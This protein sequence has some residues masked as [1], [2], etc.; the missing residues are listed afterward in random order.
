M[1]V[2]EQI[3]AR[4]QRPRSAIRSFLTKPAGHGYGDYAVRSASGRRYRVAMRSPSLFENYCSCADFAVNPLGTSMHVE[5]L[6]IRLRRRFGRSFDRQ[7][8]ER[9]RASLSLHYGGTLNV[10]IRLP[11]DASPA[12]QKIAGEHFDSKGFPGKKHLRIF[13]ALLEKLRAADE[14]V[15]VY[16]DALDSDVFSNQPG[17]PKP[18]ISPE[19]AVPV[20]LAEAEK[21]RKPA[22]RPPAL[23]HIPKPAVAQSK[24]ATPTSDG[25]RASPRAG[26]SSSLRVPDAGRAAA[27]LLEAGLDFL[28]TIAP[29][30]KGVATTS[31]QSR[32]IERVFS[33]LMRTDL[34]T[35]RP[36]FTISLPESLTAERVAGVMGRLLSKLGGMS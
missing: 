11:G 31:D 36:V 35:Q 14:T 15:I 33:S 13:E 18:I 22:I 21:V 34:Q 5:A 27:K 10:R 20:T 26:A 23:L 7:R 2:E 32:T 1:L 24:A 12:L 29:P 25:E 8:Y 19:A 28:E 16:T 17:G 9:T 3:A 30:A 4:Q 6:L